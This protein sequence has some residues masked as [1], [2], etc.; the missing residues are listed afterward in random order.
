M[1]DI[2]L[3]PAEERKARS[4]EAWRSR[5]TIIAVVVLVA[6]TLFTVATLGLFISLAQ[7]RSK[8]VS[9][10][11]EASAKINSLKTTEELITVVKTKV[12]AASGVLAKRIDYPSFFRGLAGLVPVNVY[13]SDMRFVGDKLVIVG[14]AKTSSDMA[15]LVSSLVSAKGAELLTG[16]SID[17]LSTDDQGIYGF[18]IS[19]QLL[20]K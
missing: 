13:F 16:V 4:F 11:E 18:V 15:G 7:E 3:L 1:A 2:N 8:L 9:Q 17:S 6:T 12:T 20:T 5:L 14:R 19:T 10:V